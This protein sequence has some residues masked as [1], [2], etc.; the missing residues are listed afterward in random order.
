MLQEH[1]ISSEIDDIIKSHQVTQN[2]P[3]KTSAKLSEKT[4][5]TEKNKEKVSEIIEPSEETK[6]AAITN[7]SAKKT[8]VKV[9]K[10][11]CSIEGCKK[12]VPLHQLDKDGLPQLDKAGVLSSAPLCDEH[13]PKDPLTPQQLGSGKVALYNLHLTVYLVTELLA[14]IRTNKLD[15]LTKI[16]VNQKEEV[17]VIYENIIQYYGVEN[18]ENICSPLVALALMTTGHVTTVLHNNNKKNT[19]SSIDGQIEQA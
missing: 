5:E 2:P 9:P 7:A 15:G 16:L 14:G 13:K 4:E 6:N 19:P 1:N 10:R 11:K 17:S 8:K 3:A 12:R 18:V